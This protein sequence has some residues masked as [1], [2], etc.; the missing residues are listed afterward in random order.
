MDLFKKTEAE[1]IIKVDP[2]DYGLKEQKAQEIAAMF[3]PMLNKMVELEKS[4]NKIAKIKTK[5]I[6]PELCRQA[7]ALRL[8]YVKARTETAAIHK[9]IKA[10]YLQG[11]KFVDGWKNAQ[12]MASQG[13][14]SEL[15]KIEKHFELIEEER[16]KK[17]QEERSKQLE[18]Y[19]AQEPIGLGEMPADVWENYLSGARST[20]EARRKAEAEA[21]KAKREAEL[22]KQRHEARKTSILD[23]FSFM[24][25]EEKEK[26]L[27]ELDPDQWLKLNHSLRARK[28]K[29]EK[30]DEE[31]R[32]ENERLKAQNEK[33]KQI[34]EKRKKDLSGLWSYIPGEFA[35]LN[36]TDL[37]EPEFNRTV[38]KAKIVKERS[39]NM[40]GLWSYSDLPVHNNQELIKKLQNMS[41]KQFNKTVESAKKTK[42]ESEKQKALT[43]KAKE[44]E[45]FLKSYKEAKKMA[46]Q[47]EEE[48]ILFINDVVDF[49]KVV[50]PDKTVKDLLPRA[51]KILSRL[52]GK[53]PE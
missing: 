37:P 20:Y 19:E 21:E 23:F 26:D 52:T 4:F 48:L 27:G 24:T 49:I 2:K 18:Q 3:K 47:E 8:M 13:K 25:D 44:E 41:E 42:I 43:G 35:E 45:G 34:Y 40:D 11:G 1:Q 5:D 38:E 53:D 36:F 30:E 10:F 51:K 39:E 46:D 14:E 33:R 32:K 15:L 12:L 17:I 28:E 9:E 6:K 16:I 7:R 31:I 29:K 22:K 50:S